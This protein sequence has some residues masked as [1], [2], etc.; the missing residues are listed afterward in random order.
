MFLCLRYNNVFP[1]LLLHQNCTS[2]MFSV[3]N[4]SSVDDL[5]HCA[6]FNR[7]HTSVSIQHTQPGN[8][9]DSLNGK[10]LVTL[11]TLNLRQYGEPRESLHLGIVYIERQP[12]CM[13]NYSGVTFGTKTNHLILVVATFFLEIMD[14]VLEMSL[15][16]IALKG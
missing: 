4:V 7:V 9:N 8:I 13:C 12:K 15:N 16:Y 2:L 5:T 6:P 10:T 11:Q 1:L 14:N 3:Q